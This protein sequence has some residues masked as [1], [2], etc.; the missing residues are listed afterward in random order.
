MLSFKFKCKVDFIDKK[1][2]IKLD[3]IFDYFKKTPRFPLSLSVTNAKTLDRG[4]NVSNLSES[5]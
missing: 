3:I 5:L 2:K 1:P 4:Y